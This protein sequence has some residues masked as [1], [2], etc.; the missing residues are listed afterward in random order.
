MNGILCIVPLFLGFLFSSDSIANTNRTEIPYFTWESGS[1]RINEFGSDGMP[2]A[3]GGAVGWRDGSGNLYMFGGHGFTPNGG[4]TFLNDLWKYNRRSGRWSDLTL[5][6]PGP[7][8]TPRYAASS[9]QRAR[10]F[11]VFGGHG[12]DASGRLGP[13]S[14]LWLRS[15]RGWQLVA[16]KSEVELPG[17][18]KGASTKLRPGGRYV[19]AGTSDRRGNFWLFGGEGLDERGNRGVLNDLWMFDGKHWTWVAGSNEIAARSTYTSKKA[20]PGARREMQI[21][22]D[23]QND[24]WM[25]GGEGYDGQGTYG[26][27]N[28]LWQF[29]GKQWKWVS[30]DQT[31]NGKGVYGV[32]GVPAKTNLPGAR[33]GA[34]TWLDANGTF[35]VFSGY[36]YDANGAVGF[37]QDLWKFEDS[38]WCWMGGERELST[39]GHY[40][41]KGLADPSNLPGAR[42][43]SVTW[44]FGNQ[45]WM[46]SGN[47][48]DETGAQGVLN[49]L[50]KIKF[51]KHR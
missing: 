40:G 42:T 30:G 10:H 26:F 49:D 18:Y 5:Q 34:Q 25:F 9:S 39:E 20:A 32:K 17:I 37:L 14:D 48:F 6:T 28:D 47:G 13:L 27:L 23:R 35:W 1:S 3:R 12:L 45:L 36:G 4:R 44:R 16:G 21:Y 33:T 29:D 19:A 24:L 2:A 46:F 11:F 43:N 38:K 41:D 50:W 31:R 8:P 7:A 22:S 51:R 15:K